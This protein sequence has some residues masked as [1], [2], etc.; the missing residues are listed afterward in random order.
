M[1]SDRTNIAALVV[2]GVV[3]LAVI[4]KAPLDHEVAS[5]VITGCFAVVNR[6]G[7]Q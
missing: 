4:L 6:R 3:G 2:A 7:V 5:I 1:T